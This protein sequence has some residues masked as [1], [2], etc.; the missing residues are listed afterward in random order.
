VRSALNAGAIAAVLSMLPL[1][2]VVA[3][4]LAGYLGV[5][6]YRRRSF[7]PEPSTGAGFKIG[8][9]C[10]AFGFAIFVALTAVI[11]LASHAQDKFKTAIIEAVQ[12]AQAG[13]PDNQAQSLDYFTTPHGM[14]VFLILVAVFSCVAFV[15]LSGIG[16]AI[17]A[18]LG[19]RRR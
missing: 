7:A 10:G 1:G 16:G 11:T 12:R 14:V 19:R 5:K 4:P 8:A 15:L 17:S 3:M 13:Y 6:L 2:F 18:G 9:L